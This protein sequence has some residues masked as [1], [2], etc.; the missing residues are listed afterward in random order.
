MAYVFM[1]TVFSLWFFHNYET[2]A[3]ADTSRLSRKKLELNV[4]KVFL[5]FV[6]VFPVL[7]TLSEC[8]YIFVCDVKLREIP[9]KE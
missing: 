1:F 7:I 2:E 5:F 6:E 4:L 8:E 3:V 9:A